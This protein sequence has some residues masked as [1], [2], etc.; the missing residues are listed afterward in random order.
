MSSWLEAA[1][2]GWHD[3]IVRLAKKCLVKD[4][5]ECEILQLACRRCCQPQERD[6]ATAQKKYP[7]RIEAAVSTDSSYILGSES[8][9][10]ERVLFTHLIIISAKR[11]GER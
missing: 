7:S 9:Q 8:L 6:C 4:F 3:R 10:Q 1:C 11:E 2:P 5:C